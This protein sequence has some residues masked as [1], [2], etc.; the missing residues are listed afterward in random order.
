MKYIVFATHAFEEDVV[1]AVIDV[2]EL[3]V[4]LAEKI[5]RETRQAMVGLE[6][7]PRRGRVV[8]E[9]GDER[10]RELLIA[11]ARYRMIYLVDVE[12]RLVRLLHLHSNRRPLLVD[13][14]RRR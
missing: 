9:A 4:A 11:D 1:K 2:G 8:A 12:T 7:N 14:L 6:E 13:Q 3:S 5:A 10:I